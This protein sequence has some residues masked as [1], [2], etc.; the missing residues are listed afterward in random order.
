[1]SV[2]VFLGQPIIAVGLG[3]LVAIFTL[4]RPFDRQTILQEMEKDET[5]APT[6]PAQKPIEEIITDVANAFWGQSANT[7]VSQLFK[8]TYNDFKAIIDDYETTK[9]GGTDATE[10]QKKE[11]QTS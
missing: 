9:K 6:T 5:N 3:L 2:I 4:G 11:S 7:I 1:M 10:Q 8:N